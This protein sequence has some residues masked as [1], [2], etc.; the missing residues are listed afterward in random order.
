MI[1]EAIRDAG[2]NPASFVKQT[3]FK[4]SKDWSLLVLK[5]AVRYAAQNGYEQIAWTG[6]QIQVERYEDYFRK[7]VDTIYYNK[8][9]GVLRGVKDDV[10][11]FN[12]NLESDDQL[13][14]Y[15]GEANAKQLLSQEPYSNEA[16]K[17]FDIKKLKL[18]EELQEYVVANSDYTRV[19]VAN[20]MYP[21]MMD[22]SLGQ[23]NDMGPEY[24]EFPKLFYNS[25]IIKRYQK[26]KDDTSVYRFLGSGGFEIDR[27]RDGDV[28]LS[29]DL[30]VI[31]EK[32]MRGFYDEIVPAAYNRFFYKKK[33]GKSKSKTY[34]TGMGQMP[35]VA[36]YGGTEQEF[37]IKQGDKWETFKGA[38]VLKFID[39]YEVYMIEGEKPGSKLIKDYE[40]IL[41][42]KQTEDGFFT[43]D[44][45]ARRYIL[46]ALT[47]AVDVVEDTRLIWVAPIT[48][49]MRLKSEEEG[50]PM[51]DIEEDSIPAKT[52]AVLKDKIG[53]QEKKLST[54]IVESFKEYVKN[55]ETNLLDKLHPIKDKLGADTAAYMLHRGLTGV[56]STFTHLWSMV[57][58]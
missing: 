34:N 44:H 14:E 6:G 19:D 11:V 2:F 54:K 31:D 23:W 15:V 45:Y 22:Y 51:F 25:G 17:S 10:E 9:S 16:Q 32:G 37:M 52:G 18:F 27:S 50:F 48:K 39:P 12:K 36:Y 46:P 33:W 53:R 8:K 5:R 1:D 43:P 13:S 21:A 3:P 56:Q 41:S 20:L 47:A 28:H 57:S 42:G 24:T 4:M 26:L 29:G 38:D 55:W 7:S 35:G 49:E 40:M 30:I 58:S